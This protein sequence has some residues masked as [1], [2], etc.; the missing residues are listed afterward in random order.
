MVRHFFM[1]HGGWHKHLKK[2]LEAV[3]YCIIYHFTVWGIGKLAPL[4][5]EKVPCTLHRESVRRGKGSGGQ[6][7]SGSNGLLGIGADTVGAPLILSTHE[8]DR[9][10]VSGNFSSPI[11]S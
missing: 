1:T 5:A 4:P 3:F 7:T 10:Y 8:A 11:L 2:K 9:G 6:F